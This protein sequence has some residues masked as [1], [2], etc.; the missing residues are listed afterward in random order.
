MSRRFAAL[1][2][3]TVAGGVVLTAA[4]FTYADQ[5][6]PAS[7]NPTTAGTTTTS[8]TYAGVA[9]RCTEDMDCWDCTRDGNRVCGHRPEDDAAN[10]VAVVSAISS[11]SPEP[12]LT[13]VT[14]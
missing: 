3:V 4:T 7:V 2:A 5:H 8:V 6:G 14:R 9:S 1:A 11:E 12:Q 13:I 10:V